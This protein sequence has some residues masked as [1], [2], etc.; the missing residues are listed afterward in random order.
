M[1]KSFLKSWETLLKV[2]VPP[3]N[4]EEYERLVIFLDVL[5]DIIGED[6]EH[7][8]VN[9]LEIVAILIDDYENRNHIN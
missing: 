1:D 9:L 4:E 2:L 7:I 8:L 5:L 3:H 6:E